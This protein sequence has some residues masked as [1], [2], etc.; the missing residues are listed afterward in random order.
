MRKTTGPR[1]SPGEKIVND[2]KRVTR[3]HYSS[4]EKSGSFWTACVAKAGLEIGT[5]GMSRLVLLPPSSRDEPERIDTV[6]FL[7]GFGYHLPD[8]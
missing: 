4:E 2:I 5:P 1:K 7:L 3:K 8:F 6:G